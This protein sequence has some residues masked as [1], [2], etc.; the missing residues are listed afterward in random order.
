MNYARPLLAIAGLLATL[1]TNA[2]ELKLHGVLDL[3][4]TATSNSSA[5]S[6][7]KGGSGKLHY[8]DGEQLS[9]AQ[10][11][12]EAIAQWDNGL[13]AHAVANAYLDSEDDALGLTEAFVKYRGLPDENGLRWG[14]RAGIFYPKISLENDAFAWASKYTLNSS[15][16][17]TWIGEEIRVQGLELSATRLGR[18]HDSDRDLSASL[19]VFNN[20][21]PAGALLSWHGWT[22]SH[23]QTLWT[24]SRPFP[25]LPAQAPGGMLAA[26]A[27]TSD[28]FI[29]VDDRL[30]YHL[31]GEWKQRRQGKLNLGYY[32][33]RGRPY[34][35]ENG[36]YAWRT[37]FYHL[38]GQWR[39]SKDLLLMAQYLNGDTLMQAP[40]RLDVVNNRYDSGYLLLSQR[41]GR[42]RLT[43]RG[44]L[45]SVT[46]DDLTPG[47][48]NHEHGKALTLNYSW[49]A[50]KHWFVSGEL[51]WL[52]SHRPAR[53]YQQAP[54][55]LTERQWQLAVRYFF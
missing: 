17:N 42:H 34:I 1:S 36:Q 38:G 15:T 18:F 2:A 40:T 33:N 32:D 51:N 52:D 46:D 30:G 39:L 37:R 14:L 5:T 50:S 26:Q 43:A 20:N 21:D 24:E 13:S 41:F 25:W 49:R 23:R 10:G 12:L 3:R 54:V 55:N 4:A 6:Y 7:L 31:Q 27:L 8:S 53:R 19:T 35:Q 16:L 47:D 28:P 22:Q 48:N 44:E 11:G 9:L 45:F 29:E